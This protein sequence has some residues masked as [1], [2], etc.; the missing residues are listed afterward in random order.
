M[1]EDEYETPKNSEK[2][3]PQYSGHGAEWV[4]QERTAFEVGGRWVP[5]LNNWSLSSGVNCSFVIPRHFKDK[6]NGR[7]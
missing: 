5:E 3:P 1:N 4:M 7:S 6:V 2:K